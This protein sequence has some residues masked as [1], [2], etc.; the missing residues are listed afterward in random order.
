M[1]NEYK[2]YE[3][4]IPT[5]ILYKSPNQVPNQVFNSPPIIV[6]YPTP[7]IATTETITTTKKRSRK[8]KK[9]KTTTTTDVPSV[10]DKD[11]YHDIDIRF[12][13]NDYEDDRPIWRT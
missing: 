10:I 11:N 9:L 1:K 4:E 3:I 2:I 5:N 6:M 12:A 13:G 8:R 7:S